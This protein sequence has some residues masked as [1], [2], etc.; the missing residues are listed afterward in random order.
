M[1]GVVIAVTLV[2]LLSCFIALA[3]PP[4]ISP[5]QYE[6]FCEAQKVSGTG[7]VDVSTSIVDKK[8]ALEYFNNMAGDG[9]LELDQE[10]AY[11]QN[12]DKLLRNITSVNG[13]DKSQ[14]NLY[15]S[16]KLTYAGDT[17]LVGAKHMQSKE[18]YGGIGATIDENFAV[19][20]MEK[21][22]TAFFVSTA[23]TT[24]KWPV[25]PVN[26]DYLQLLAL[27]YP[28]EYSRYM[29]QANPTMTPEE[30]IKALKDAGRDTDRVAALM[31]NNAAHVIGMDTKNSF[32][33]TWGTDATWHKIFYKDIKAHE[34]F[35]GVF[36]AEKLI[37]FHENPVP[38]KE[39][40]P[41]DGIDC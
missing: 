35:S 2:L 5:I 30:L 24:R 10:H 40:V 8:L 29:A 17:P 18:F 12:A 41:C 7:V 16:T 22:Q 31:G 11:S 39:K 38:E 37:K 26:Q 14:L 34:M 15:E 25:D 28:E 19:F 13:G 3:N 21:D 6:Q 4:L 32:N 23:P 33:G 36:E 27:Y 9:D 1:K 20:E